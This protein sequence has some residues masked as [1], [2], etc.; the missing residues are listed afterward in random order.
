M[1]LLNKLKKIRKTMNEEVKNV[2]LNTKSDDEK[3]S[4]MMNKINKMIESRIQDIFNIKFKNTDL[5]KVKTLKNAY[6]INSMIYFYP[7]NDGMPTY[8]FKFYKNNQLII[9]NQEVFSQIN[10][11]DEILIKMTKIISHALDNN[12]IINPYNFMLELKD[13][14]GLNYSGRAELVMTDGTIVNDKLSEYDFNEAREYFINRYLDHFIGWNFGVSVNRNEE[15]RNLLEELNYKVI[16]MGLRKHA[17]I[18]FEVYGTAKDICHGVQHYYFET[19][20][21]EDKFKCLTTYYK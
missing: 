18:G 21:E 10:N 20:R 6:E 3:L 19:K 13:K 17:G 16:D 5:V 8:P 11:L 9:D 2:N 7:P 14:I 4:E 12:I 15:L 1:N